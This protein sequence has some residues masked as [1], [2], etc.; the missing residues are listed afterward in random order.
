MTDVGRPA[1]MVGLTETRHA[2]ER[3]AEEGAGIV[4]ASRK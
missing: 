4:R 3:P 1:R 2:N